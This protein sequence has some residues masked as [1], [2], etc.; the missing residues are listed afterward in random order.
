[1][2]GQKFLHTKVNERRRGWCLSLV[3]QPGS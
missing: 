1:L 3:L 2:G